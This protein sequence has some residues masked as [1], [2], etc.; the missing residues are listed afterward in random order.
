MVIEQETLPLIEGI[1]HYGLQ[2]LLALG[3]L[4]VLSLIIAYLVAT[5]LYGPIA[6]GRE[7]KNFL[8]EI[9]RDWFYTS[10][11]RVLALAWLAMK[12]SINRRVLVVAVIFLILLLFAGWYLDNRGD[13]AAKMYLSFVFTSMSVLVIVLSVVLSAFSLPSDLN[14]RTILLIVAKPVRRHEIVLGRVLGFLATGT[15]LL[16]VMGGISYFFVSRGLDHTHVLRE[17]EIALEDYDPTAEN[18]IVKRGRTAMKHGHRHEVLFYKNGDIY[19]EDTPGH[20]HRAE[21]RTN[22]Q[23]EEIVQLGEPLSILRARVPR[24]G[25]LLFR[26]R[27]GEL[28]DKGIN[29]GT[30]WKYKTCIE[31]GTRSAGIWT[32][33]DLYEEEFPN[34][35]P[36]ELTLGVYRSYKGDIDSGILGSLRLRNPTDGRTSNP[37]LFRAKEY[38]TDRLFIPRTVDSPEGPLDLFKH[39]VVD[40]KVEMEV[41]CEERAQYFC[42]AR[43]DVYARAGDAPF[44]LN[45]VKGLTGIWLQMLLI[46]SVGVAASTVLRGSV[47]MALTIGIALSGHLLDSLKTLAQGENYGG[48]PLEALIRILTNRNLMVELPNGFY[49]GPTKMFDAAMRGLLNAVTYIV[50]DF[51]LYNMADYV[52]QGFNINASQLASN[53]VC[54]VTYSLIVIIIGHLCLKLRQVA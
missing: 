14:S 54:G 42:M 50:P 37:I 10:P 30:E 26:D 43:Y 11:R 8:S 47:A 9:C 2:M 39:F 22:Q 5:A 13:I 27:N 17:S 51:R 32:F 33:E 40:G 7:L 24:Y 45:F 29:V 41:R 31:G 1:L 19:V 6:G 46:L 4:G 35:V 21:V 23:G 53:I 20:S 3:I 38:Y 34:G 44:S 28:Q 12:E 25:T 36:L 15:I 18:P 48:G 16:A 52:A 49:L